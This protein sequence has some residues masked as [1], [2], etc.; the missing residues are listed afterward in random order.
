LAPTRPPPVACRATSAGRVRGE[1]EPAF[2]DA[3]AGDPRHQT[4]AAKRLAACP[5]KPRAKAGGG[6]TRRCRPRPAPA[7]RST[8]RLAVGA[9]ST[10]GQAAWP[11]ARASTTPKPE[12]KVGERGGEHA[13]ASLW[14][15][16]TSWATGT[17][18]R[19]PTALTRKPR[20]HGTHGSGT[21]RAAQR[22]RPAAD[23][24]MVVPRALL[25]ACRGPADT[26]AGLA[27]RSRWGD[28]RGF[29]DR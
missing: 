19:T 21:V 10:S 17:S 28:N 29:D 4:T 12:A 18:A 9:P 22:F 1:V 15:A 2:A 3:P 5:P 16:P 24:P 11:S 26:S 13:T 20:S 27:R 14:N 6:R 7:G 23:S 25:V 8:V